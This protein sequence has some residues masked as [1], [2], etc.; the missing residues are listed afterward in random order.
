M[1]ITTLDYKEPSNKYLVDKVIFLKFSI[2]DKNKLVE[3]L[4]TPKV[5]LEANLKT[6]K[7][8]FFIEENVAINEL[9]KKEISQIMELDE[10]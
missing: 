2:S 5:K 1:N 3:N 8:F 4:A 10:S 7:I 6:L 9:K